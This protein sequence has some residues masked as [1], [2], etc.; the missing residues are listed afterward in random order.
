MEGKKQTKLDIILICNAER[1]DGTWCELPS[2]HI[3]NHRS[4][5][6]YWSSDEKDQSL[7]DELKAIERYTALATDG[8]WLVGYDGAKETHEGNNDGIVWKVAGADLG[9]HIANT[10]GHEANAEFIARAR[11]DIPKLIEIIRIQLATLRDIEEHCRNHHG[12][13][14]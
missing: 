10:E 8:P 5:Q 1:G 4:S 3:G 13:K 14:C 9:W 7:E 12:Q 6:T 11:T 2:D